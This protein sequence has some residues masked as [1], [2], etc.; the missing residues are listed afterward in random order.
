MNLC[1]TKFLHNQHF[2]LLP[3]AY[4]NLKKIRIACMPY[5]VMFVLKYKTTQ[6]REISLFLVFFYQVLFFL[7]KIYYIGVYLPVLY[8]I[9]QW[10]GLG[11]T[12]LE[13]KDRT[14]FFPCDHISSWVV[15]YRLVSYNQAS[16]WL[17]ILLLLLLWRILTSLSS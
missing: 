17:F 15:W 9:Y 2:R 1:L 4:I 13:L 11:Y 3:A 8:R 7:L 10:L 14:P 16:S 12:E 6:K 5:C